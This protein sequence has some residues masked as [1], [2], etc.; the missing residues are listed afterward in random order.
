[1]CL[2]CGCMLPYERHG[3]DRNLIVDD[4]QDSTKTEQAK[5]LTPNDAIK[6]LKGTWEEKVEEGV[7]NTRVNE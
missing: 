1:M 7:R 3:D 6:N 4:I 2:T 5:G